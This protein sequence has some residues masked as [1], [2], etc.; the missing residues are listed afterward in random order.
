MHKL[1]QMRPVSNREPITHRRLQCPWLLSIKVW[2]GENVLIIIV[3]RITNLQIL[4]VCLNQT[5]TYEYT[6]TCVCS[7]GIQRRIKTYLREFEMILQG[8]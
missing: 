1:T 6:Y 7:F 2:T 3:L 4:G 8:T 5:F